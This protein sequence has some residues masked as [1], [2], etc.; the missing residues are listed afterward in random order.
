MADAEMEPALYG[1][2]WAI[3]AGAGQ[4]C[5]AGSRLLIEASIQ[6]EFVARLA[7]LARGLRLGGPDVEADMGPLISSRQQENVLSYIEVGRGEAKLV[8]GGGAPQDPGLQGGYFVEPTIFD[9]VGPNATIAREEIFGPVL[10]VTPFEDL[11]QALDIANSSDY[12]LASAIWT[13]NL[14]TA[15]TVAE[16]LE[17]AQVYVNH[18]F[19][20]GFEVSRTP[21]KASGFGHSEGPDAIN[22]FLKAKTVSINMGT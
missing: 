20:A 19:S 11:D 21:Y 12:G 16:R 22:E 7:E 1:A 13:T 14:R 10:T 9:N 2:L 4:I 3:F 5:V 8:T 15:H 18:Y 17:A 6:D